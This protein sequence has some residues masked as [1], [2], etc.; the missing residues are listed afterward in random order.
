MV[1]GA[2]CTVKVAE[3]TDPQGLTCLAQWLCAGHVRGAID[4]C[5]SRPEQ[6]IALAGV[7]W[8]IICEA[9]RRTVEGES[10]EVIA[11]GLYPMTENVL[12]ELDR[13]LKAS[14]APTSA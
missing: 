7:F 9:G 6:R 10:Q 5:L 13:W 2:R 14:R 12:D 8:I 4:H 11:D 3:R 1:H